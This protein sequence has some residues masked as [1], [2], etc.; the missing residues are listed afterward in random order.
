MLP[1]HA[2]PFSLVLYF[3]YKSDPVQFP[4]SLRV[5]SLKSSNITSFKNAQLVREEAPA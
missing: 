1:S 5:Q 2:A 3:Y 4:V